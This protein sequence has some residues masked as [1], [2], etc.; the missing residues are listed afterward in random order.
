MQHG[1]IKWYS[2]IRGQQYN[3]SK[4]TA[5]NK[6]CNAS[7]CS[8]SIG[9]G[10]DPHPDSAPFFDYLQDAN[11]KKKISKFLCLFLFEGKSTSFF[12]E[13]NPKKLQYS[14]KSRF[15]FFFCLLMEGYADPDPADQKSMRIRIRIQ[16]TA[17]EYRVP[18]STIEQ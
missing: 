12:N 11:K 6:Q 8:G 16:N 5:V 4:L 7:Q 2:N 9:K 3:S 13:K 18:V 17:V 1:D 10:A 14:R 15:F